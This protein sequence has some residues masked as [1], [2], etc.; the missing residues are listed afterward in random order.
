MRSLIFTSLA[1]LVL[2]SCSGNSTE[3][4]GDTT[5]AVM[6]SAESSDETRVV[7]NPFHERH[8]ADRSIFEGLPEHMRGIGVPAQCLLISAD[9]AVRIES[10]AREA[11]EE[12]T[13]HPDLR[14][15]HFFL[16]GTGFIY[17]ILHEQPRGLAG[18]VDSIEC[19]TPE[20][21]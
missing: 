13:E 10:D 15:R 3:P 14:H 18:H 12:L 17:L 16:S 19:F 20:T 2:S 7:P 8:S 21:A 9:S 4:V 1:S 5:K 6:V 11:G